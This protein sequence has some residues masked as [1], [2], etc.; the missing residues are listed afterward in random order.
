VIGLPEQEERYIGVVTGDIRRVRCADVWVNPENTEMVM[1]R[2]NEFSVSSIVR[3]EG[4]LRDDM[5]HVIDDRIAD[6]LARKVAGRTPV[7]PGT[8]ILSGPGELTR[9]RVKRIIHV[10]AVQGEP[11]AGFRQILEVGRCVTNAM[12]EADKA[13]AQPPLATILFPLLGTGQGGGDLTAT[14]TALVGSAID[15]FTASPLSRISTVYFLAYT[16][17]EMAACETLVTTSKRLIPETH[18]RR[19][20]GSSRTS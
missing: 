10:A 20:Q 16:E 8:A 6:D 5:G 17:A 14:I 1:A 11:G 15:Y 13:D 3:Y 4:A 7:L 12:A 19:H 9:Y 2:F 18:D